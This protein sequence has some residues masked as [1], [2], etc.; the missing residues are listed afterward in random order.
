MDSATPLRYAQNDRYW[1][2]AALREILE[3]GL[4]LFRRLFFV[5]LRLCARSS[6]QRMM[7][8]SSQRLASAGILVAT[9]S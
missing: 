4:L 5:S 7:K 8:V 9:L 2:S 6:F 1:I 3:F